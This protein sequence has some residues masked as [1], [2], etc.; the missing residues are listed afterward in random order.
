[1]QDEE[2]ALKAR[3]EDTEPL[4][5]GRLAVGLGRKE[6]LTTRGGLEPLATGLVMAEVLAE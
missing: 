5:G 3:A 2:R 4:E 1:M 6:C